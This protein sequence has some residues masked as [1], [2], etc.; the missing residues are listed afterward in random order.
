MVFVG[1][2]ILLDCEVS[3]PNAEVTWKKNGEEIEE[4]AKVTISEDGLNRQLAI[5]S[6]TLED[7]GQ[8]MCDAKDDVMDFHVSVTG[9][10]NFQQMLLFNVHL[11]IR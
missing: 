5:Q 10:S 4:N 9:N 6:A 1:D 8:Y 2:P 3:R 7:A 11:C